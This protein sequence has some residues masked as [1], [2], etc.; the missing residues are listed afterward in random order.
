[1]CIVLLLHLVLH[2]MQL[3]AVTTV[4]METCGVSEERALD[5]REKRKR[6][7]RQTEGGRQEQEAKRV[8]GIGLQRVWS[9]V[10]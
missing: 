5:R 3:A 7:E 2:T 10:G 4:A 1:M 8:G 9:K 6:E